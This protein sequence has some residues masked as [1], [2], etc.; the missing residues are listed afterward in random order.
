VRP[1]AHVRKL[2]YM[3]LVAVKECTD[4][5]FLPERYRGLSPEEVE[6]RIEQLRRFM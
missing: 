6:E 4:V 5:R 1:S 2:E 3:D